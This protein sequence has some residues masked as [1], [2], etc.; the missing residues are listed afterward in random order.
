MGSACL[1]TPTPFPSPWSRRFRRRWI[2]Q[3]E[4]LCC[5]GEG[6]QS[7]PLSSH[8]PLP[9]PHSY[10]LAASE[11]PSGE[12]HRAAPRGAGGGGVER[13]TRR[14]AAARLALTPHPP[15]LTIAAMTPVPDPSPYPPAACGL[16]GSG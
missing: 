10:P 13:S 6:R 4:G 5:R 9:S 14:P 3:G 2:G 11:S 15:S 1:F 12:A 16:L 7:R 8:D